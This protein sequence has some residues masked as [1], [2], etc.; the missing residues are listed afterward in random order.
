[1]LCPSGKI[2]PVDGGMIPMRE[3]HNR[4]AATMW[5]NSITALRYSADARR[6]AGTVSNE[7]STLA[8]ASHSYSNQRR[9]RSVISRAIK[10]PLRKRERLIS[11]CIGRSRRDVENRRLREHHDRRG[12]R[13]DA[14]LRISATAHR[15]VRRVARCE[16]SLD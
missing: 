9:N 1:A 16:S 7:R 14:A 5:P 6:S 2:D 10:L 3:S 15:K 8:C 4:R 12:K 13:E 11:G